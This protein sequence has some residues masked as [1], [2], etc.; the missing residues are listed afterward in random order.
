MTPRAGRAGDAVRCGLLQFSALR[1][2]ALCLH[3]GQL[4]SRIAAY[5]NASKFKDSAPTFARYLR[6]LGYRTCFS[7]KM[8]FVG[9]DQ[10]HGF[11]D[12]VTTDIYPADFAWTPDW[13]ARD[14]RIDKR[15]HNMQTVKESGQAHATFRIDY[16]DTVGFAAR[17]WLFD[18]ARDTALGDDRPFAMVASFIHAHAP[19]VARPEWWSL[20]ADED[21]DKPAHIPATED[22]DPFSRRLMDGIEASYVPLT[23]EEVPAPATPISPM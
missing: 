22:Q 2:V 1:A 16:D 19:Y 9:P 3:S 14:E 7:G 13:E 6:S 5:D 4:I 20:Y 21:I 8:H 10:M 17:R 15:Y 12:R 23:D 11:E 18:A